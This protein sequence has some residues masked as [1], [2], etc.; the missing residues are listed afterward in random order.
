MLTGL[1]YNTEVKPFIV[2][3]GDEIIF[4][5]TDDADPKTF[6]YGIVTGRAMAPGCVMY[7]VAPASFAPTQGPSSHTLLL[8]SWK[9]LVFWDFDKGQRLML[10]RGI[11]CQDNPLLMVVD[12]RKVELHADGHPVY[13][14]RVHL[15]FSTSKHYALEEHE[16]RRLNNAEVSIK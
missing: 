13:R 5:T 11:A 6:S 12:E 15:E 10:A 16:L 8:I 14:Y 9:M 4:K 3:V 1:G 7:V 2:N